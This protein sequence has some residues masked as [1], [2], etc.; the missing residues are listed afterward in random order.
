MFSSLSLRR[1][2]LRRSW[3]RAVASWLLFVVLLVALTLLTSFTIG[4][5]NSFVYGILGTGAAVAATLALYRHQAGLLPGRRTLT[6]FALGLLTGVGLIAL[7]VVVICAV[8]G[9]RLVPAGDGKLVPV[10]LMLLSFLPLALMEEIPFR[11]APFR[12][13]TERYG[14]RA[15]Q[16]IGA[17]AFA[18]YHVANGWG[19][20]QSFLGPG[21]WALV[22]GIAAAR[23]GGIAAPTGLHAGVNIGQR[24]V[25]LGTGATAPLWQ[26]TTGA[27]QTGDVAERMLPAGMAFQV[28]LALGAPLLTEMFTRKRRTQSPTPNR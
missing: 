10:V 21:L 12:H 20:L 14:L 15:A 18:L 3:L 5:P 17:L 13:L 7:M 11:G 24:L 9:L 1:P 23:S 22:F 28:L 2:L 26:I 25:G 4:Q 8:S 6:H 16:L 27:G 19:I